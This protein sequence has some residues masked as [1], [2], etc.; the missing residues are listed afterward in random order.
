MPVEFEDYEKDEDGT[1]IVSETDCLGEGYNAPVYFDGFGKGYFVPVMRKKGYYGELQG[2]VF[3]GSVYAEPLFLMRKCTF[4]CY[5]RGNS[6]W[7]SFLG[8]D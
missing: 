4:L 8:K 3:R 5:R 1:I 7:Q 6:I 2:E